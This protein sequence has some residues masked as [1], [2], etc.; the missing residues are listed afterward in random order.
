MD[1][2]QKNRLIMRYLRE[3]SPFQERSQ[4]PADDQRTFAGL[5]TLLDYIKES[6]EELFDFETL[7]ND[8]KQWQELRKVIDYCTVFH[9][10]SPQILQSINPD[11][12]DF[13][14]RFFQNNRA[15]AELPSDNYFRRPV[16]PA[17]EDPDLNSLVVESRAKLYDLIKQILGTSAF[18]PDDVKDINLR[19][20]QLDGLIAGF[21]GSEPQKD[22]SALIMLRNLLSDLNKLNGLEIIRIPQDNGPS[23]IY[24]KLP[25]PME[26]VTA[27]VSLVSLDTVKT[28]LTRLCS[29]EDLSVE[30][31]EAKRVGNYQ[32]RTEAILKLPKNGQITE[33]QRE[34]MALNISRMMGLDTTHSTTVSY[35]GRPALFVPF[36]NIRLLKDFA[37]GQT[38]FAGL[39]IQGKTYTHY[40]TINPVGEGVQA[41]LFVDDSGANLGL[42]Y[43][44]SDTDAIGG[45]CQNKALRNDRSWYIF[46]QVLMADLKMAL[47]SRL[48]L[49]PCQFLGKYTR[50]G[51]G[52]NR[53]LVEDSSMVAKFASIMQL[54]DLQEQILQYLEQSA[55]L[56]H[57][58]AEE[59]TERLKTA[60]LRAE[61]RARLKVELSD[62]HALEMDALV[63]KK[64]VAERIDMLQEVLPSTQGEVSSTDLR[65]ALIIEKL[66]HNPVLFCD[67]GRPY[68]NPW[69]NKHS[70]PIQSIEA[71]DNGLIQIRFPHAVSQE[72][73]DFIKRRGAGESMILASANSLHINK[74]HLHQLHENML[75]PEN[76]LNLS[77]TTRYLYPE[78]LRLLQKAYNQTKEPELF[79]ILKDYQD[80]MNPEDRRRQNKI[81]A[82]L[83]AESKLKDHI[84]GTKHKGLATHLLKK[85]YF[86]AQQQLFAMIPTEKL[87]SQLNEA[88][89]AALKLDRASDFIKVLCAAI[90]GAK[91]QDPNFIE[92]LNQCI[93][94]AATAT[95][96]T[97]AREESL[98]LS[99]DAMNTLQSFKLSSTAQMK[100]LYQREDD[101][102]DRFDPLA[103]LMVQL[104]QE[105]ALILGLTAPRAESEKPVKM[106]CDQIEQTEQNKSRLNS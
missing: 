8:D 33:V 63:L 78:D 45:Y 40:S 46:D 43:V 77:L 67:D 49:V 44:C 99:I 54:I 72:M 18:N 38:F 42:L 66:L 91:T 96:H 100:Q 69:T 12:I 97:H 34:A 62:V 101:V 19:I 20:N 55:W 2:V 73:F 28:K 4:S 1:S 9:K 70:N 71:L 35:D 98:S 95:N 87:P 50:H 23:L 6:N 75:H 102:F 80:Q 51:Q 82:I 61:E 25:E 81:D 74:N 21:V 13:A 52:R 30:S 47:D 90:P 65:Q 17:A 29:A 22:T 56:H 10:E 32:L 58:R 93:K 64:R 92:F 104:R 86:D 76:D 41:D 16:S 88:F 59:I 15:L 27:K 60:S 84:A 26:G 11:Q 79:Q 103:P 14:L 37:K 57:N 3:R 94:R 48:N 53:T 68:K 5:S 24:C 39:G 89:S 106:E 7:E 105:K 85:F 83:V 36:D 31:Y